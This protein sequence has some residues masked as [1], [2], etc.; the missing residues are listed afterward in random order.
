MESYKQ[1]YLTFYKTDI[2]KDWEIHHIDYC[3]TNNTPTNL[4]ALPKALH[5]KLHRCYNDYIKVFKHFTLS[6]IKLHTG[7]QT[8][9]TVFMEYLKNYL[10]VIEECIPYMNRRESL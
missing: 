7:L 3:H 2:P 10:D 8:N 1:I 5:Q 9:H 4:V 6:D